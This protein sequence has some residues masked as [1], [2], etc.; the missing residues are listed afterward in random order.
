MVSKGQITSVDFPGAAADAVLGLTNTGAVYGRYGVKGPTVSDGAYVFQNGAFTVLNPPGS[1]SPSY[2]SIFGASPSGDFYGSFLDKAT[3]DYKGFVYSDGAY[4]VLQLPGARYTY[5]NSMNAS[6]EI[7]GLYNIPGGSGAEQAFLY[8]KGIY[9]A[10]DFSLT[11]GT[12][13]GSEINDN[14]Q[15]LGTLGNSEIFLATPDAPSAPEPV[16]PLLV[17]SGLVAVLLIV[18]YKHKPL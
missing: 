13:L 16:S 8:D 3:F 9:Q 17:G 2:V 12:T 15:I 4:Q 11:G 18:R 7:L 1:W 10:L 5:I 14:G 6:G